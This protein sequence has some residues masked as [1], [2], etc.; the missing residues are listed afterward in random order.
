VT[1]FPWLSVLLPLA[2]V[3]FLGWLLLS[4]GGKKTK[5]RKSPV[6][7]SAT[8]SSPVQGWTGFLKKLSPNNL[9]GGKLWTWC[10]KHTSKAKSITYNW[11]MM[12]LMFWGISEVFPE[13]LEWF[14]QRPLV[15]SILLVALGFATV[16]E[17]VVTRQGAPGKA[18]MEE[19]RY[20]TNFLRSPLMYANIILVVLVIMKYYH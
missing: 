1:F 2:A 19:Y 9:V 20:T 17:R 18:P 10:V 14:F 4:L 8:S 7:P 15:P 6:S 13:K 3:L 16:R 11:V 5:K 12:A